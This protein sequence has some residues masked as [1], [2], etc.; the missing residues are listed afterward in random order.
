MIFFSTTKSSVKQG[1]GLFA[2]FCLPILLM[3]LKTVTKGQ[4]IHDKL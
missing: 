1:V 4:E 2:I 3:P